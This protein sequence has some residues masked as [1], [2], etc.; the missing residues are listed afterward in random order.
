MV[1]ILLDV[2]ILFH[3]IQIPSKMLTENRRERTG[4]RY[5]V[6]ACESSLFRNMPFNRLVKLEKAGIS[7][8]Q[9]ATP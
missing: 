1:T 6:W 4:V 7:T 8:K 9:L 5:C 3:F 2:G